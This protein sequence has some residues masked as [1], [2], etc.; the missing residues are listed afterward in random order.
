MSD[1]YLKDELYERVQSSPEIFEFL[2]A[3]SLDGIWYW[4][5][6][7]PEREWMSPR[8]WT[9]FGHDPA[10]RAHL[11]SEWQDMIFPEDRELALENFQK[12]CADP[13]HAYDQLVR[14]RHKDGS[15]V[16]VRCRG[17]A[18]RD[19]QGRPTRM[20]GAHTNITPLM[21][22][23][24]RLR[25][26]N[27]DLQSRYEAIIEAAGQLFYEWDPVSDEVAFVNL[28]DAPGYAAGEVGGQLAD[29]I[30][31]I[32]PEDRSRFEAALERVR[33]SRES[34]YLEYRIRRKDGGYIPVE[35]RGY[36]IAD[37]EDEQPRLLGFALDVS[38]KKSLEE[39]FR[40]SQKMDAIGRLAVGVAH[41]FNN[42]LS[43]ILC[44]SEMILNEMAEDD[45]LRSDIALIHEAGERSADLT[46]QLLAFG[47][48]QMLQPRVVNINATVR[49]VDRMLR[50]LIGEDVNL[51]T[52]LSPDL[53]RIRVDPGQIEQ[54]L[55]NLAVNARDAMPDGGK[56]T[57]ET[58]NVCLDE[59]DAENHADGRPGPHVMIAVSDTGGGNIRVYSEPGTGT[60]L[61]IYLPRA[62]EPRV[63]E[64]VELP[65]EEPVRDRKTI[66]VVEDEPAVRDI[67]RR[68]LARE[69]Y[70]LL[71]AADG[72]E[73]FATAAG[74][75]GPIHLLL[76]DVVL[77][78][79]KG[80]EVAERILEERPA[81]RLIYMSGYTDNAVLRHGALTSEVSF[82]EKPLRPSILSQRIREV[83]DA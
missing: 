43:V 44:T 27:V 8:F 61:K 73:A 55:I 53:D 65:L 1:H 45:P 10:E 25:R 33:E 54:I 12:H 19:E 42:I 13:K 81:T 47:R 11:A 38:E 7:D 20:L 5:L 63:R 76:T 78:T 80:P 34:F 9:T 41:D 16:W 21:E 23:Q 72:E 17:L 57:I 51:V 49:G 59:G 62:E 18:I 68:T 50:R 6:E 37:G 82:L 77:P 31:L 69:G 26:R 83:L 52:R 28:E 46:R 24:A 71:L 36:F 60:T 48:K 29:R 58:R 40:Q 75:D 2:Q 67:I 64:S 56:L 30:E 4:D 14:Y 66:L 32:H 3:G 70:H 79:I 35:D 74:F 39:R 15:T 22:A